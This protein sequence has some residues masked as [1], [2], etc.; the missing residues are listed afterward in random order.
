[1]FV[2]EDEI[3]I[4]KN[5]EMLKL[6]EKESKKVFT[7]EERNNIINEDC[8]PLS[9]DYKKIY[10]RGGLFMKETNDVILSKI[11]KQLDWKGKIVGRLFPKTLIKVYNNS[12]INT[13]N[14]FLK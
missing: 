3:K 6:K 7:N 8:N 10:E 4:L 9:K 14:D 13:L 2:E 12:R 11:M 1:M 5:N